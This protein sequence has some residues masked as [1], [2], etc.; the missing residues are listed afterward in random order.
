MNPVSLIFSS[1]ANHWRIHDLGCFLPSLY[2]STSLLTL[3]INVLSKLEL[4]PKA[5]REMN[6]AEKIHNM[7]PACRVQLLSS[8]PTPSWLLPALDP[9]TQD[10]SRF[11]ALPKTSWNLVLCMGINDSATCWI[12][13][14]LSRVQWLLMKHWCICLSGQLFENSLDFFQMMTSAWHPVV[15]N[16]L[17]DCATGMYF[18]GKLFSWMPA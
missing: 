15:W 13:Y 18:V 11:V 1:L 4:A 17:L 16:P 9:Q 8:A 14:A 7:W 10:P 2:I 5:S 6:N 3:H 12:K